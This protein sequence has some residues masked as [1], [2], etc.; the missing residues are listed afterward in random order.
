MCE[1]KWGATRFTRTIWRSDLGSFADSSV[2]KTV[3]AAR[4][5]MGKSKPADAD[6]TPGIARELSSTCSN[7]VGYLLRFRKP[8]GGKVDTH[9][10]EVIGTKAGIQA[11]DVRKTSQARVA[12]ITSVTASATSPTTNSWRNRL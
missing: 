4:S 5:P 3:S 10:N 12:P 2:A 11:E 9:G 7:E 8:K 1:K 6:S